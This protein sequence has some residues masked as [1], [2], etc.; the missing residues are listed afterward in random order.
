MPE[1][2]APMPSYTRVSASWAAMVSAGYRF[3]PFFGA[4]LD[5]NL[6][7][8]RWDR[9]DSWLTEEYPHRF[10][11]VMPTLRGFIALSAVDIWVGLGAG[12]QRSTA[13]GES[14]E[15]KIIENRVNL[16][17]LKYE[18]GVAFY[19]TRKLSLGFSAQSIRRIDD[20]GEIKICVDRPDEAETC[21]TYTKASDPRFFRRGFDDLLQYGVVLRF[22]L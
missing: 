8:H 7:E 20:Q 4:Y 12:Y 22:R 19:L 21:D 11:S 6:G 17:D 18:A 3:H 15:V 1:P 10:L 13:V 16:L 14:S 9:A 2:E 5:V